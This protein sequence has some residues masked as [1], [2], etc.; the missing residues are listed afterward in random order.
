VYVEYGNETWNTGFC[1]WVWCNQKAQELGLG[2]V[3]VGFYCEPWRKYNV[4]AS[5]RAFQRFESK[6]GVNSSRLVKVIGGQVGYHWPGFDFNHMALGDFAA[7]NNAVI[8]PSQITINAWAIAPYMGGQS[9]TEMRNELPETFQHVQWAKNS[10]NNTP[11][12]LLCYEGGSDNY[13][14]NSLAITR[15]AGQRQLYVDFLS[16]LD[17][18]VNGVFNQYCF[19]G[20]CWGLKV[21]AGESA[22]IN[23]KWQGW[24]DYWNAHPPAR[25]ALVD[26]IITQKTFQVYPNPV[27]GKSIRFNLWSDK[28][29]DARLI[30]YSS[31]SQRMFETQRPLTAG[32]TLITL[33][34][35]QLQNGVY[36]LMIKKGDERM[37]QKVVISK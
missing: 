25:I 33:P 28:A 21:D 2:N 4:Y 12:S 1:T 29:G 34:V 15:N 23:P 5:V 31:T 13:P 7:L 24:L 36:F 35:D 20:G 6:F 19:Y 37:V 17:D 10:L 32:N 30:M 3:D 8:N 18:Y 27:N 26:S 14:D 22:S 16:G 11:Y 9:V